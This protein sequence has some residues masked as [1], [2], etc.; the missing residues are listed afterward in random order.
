MI[1]MD[2]V[3]Y[4]IKE[5][6]R[7]S[8]ER[9]VGNIPADDFST[10]TNMLGIAWWEEEKRTTKKYLA[11]RHVLELANK[12]VISPSLMRPRLIKVPTVKTEVINFL[13]IDK[14]DL[15][16]SHLSKIIKDAYRRLAKTHHPDRGGDAK[17]FRKLH[18][19]Y[20]ELLCW[21][22]SPTF[23]RRRGFSDKWYYDGENRKWIQPVPV[24][25]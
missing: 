7:Y 6:F 13:E 25:N 18:A 10:M 8:S 24:H 19:A 12:C 17:A 5:I 16:S 3:P 11:S 4:G 23:I 2:V 22:D 1:Y 20:T 15:H 14:A 21:A 9:S